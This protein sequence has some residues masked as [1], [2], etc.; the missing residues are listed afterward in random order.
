M[1]K[2]IKILVLFSVLLIGLVL[3]AC[4]GGVETSNATPESSENP[5][6]DNS[7]S[8]TTPE[9]SEN[10]PPDNS[11][12]STTIKINISSFS[13]NYVNDYIESGESSS[14]TVTLVGAT[15]LE[16]ISLSNNNPEILSLGSPKC[17]MNESGEVCTV[18]V[19][20]GNFSVSADGYPTQ[21]SESLNVIGFQ[22]VQTFY[23]NVS[24]GANPYSALVAGTDGILYGTTT[25]GGDNNFG[26]IYSINPTTGAESTLWSFG[27]LPNDGKQSSSQLLQIESLLYGTT[28]SGGANGYGTV[29][30]Y[31]ITTGTESVIYSFQG[32]EG[33]NPYS[34]LIES[35]GILYGTTAGSGRINICTGNAQCGSVYS[36][37][38]SNNQESTIHIFS[39]DDGY[40]PGAG[41][42]YFG[43]R[44]YGVTANG[45]P[46]N[47]GSIFSFQPDNTYGPSSINILYYFGAKESDGLNPFAALT[48]FN[49]KLYGTTRSGGTYYSGSIY[50]FDPITQQ[51]NILYS[52]NG[53]YG[54]APIAS[55]IESGG[56]LFGTTASGMS[57]YSGGTVFSFNPNT[58]T[59]DVIKSFYMDKDNDPTGYYP[60][61]SLMI[62]N[63]FIY[64][65]NSEGSNDRSE[66]GTVFRIGF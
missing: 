6:S 58:G 50:S 30:S 24:A 4:N 17:I 12:S 63:D 2:V 28:I 65:T 29:F 37:D 46:F 42:T 7:G 22:V 43:G 35:N 34:G 49:N 20:A 33:M 27:V 59:E 54:A 5:P 18:P 51:E 14:T 23:K 8:S 36:I 66:A 26:T 15:S 56:I 38:L 1:L 62:Y 10:P 32:S 9:S 39:Y 19:D 21:V 60:L 64:G 25:Q 61:S 16:S 13:G 40:S 11:G 41:L 57:D 31:N 47:S 52:F 44:I 55:L 45:G 3:V 53:R 48:V